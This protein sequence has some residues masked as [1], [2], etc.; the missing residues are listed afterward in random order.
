MVSPEAEGKDGKETEGKG[1][2]A[3]KTRGTKMKVVIM[4]QLAEEEKGAVEP[5]ESDG[6]RRGTR[7]ATAFSSQ[8]VRR[9]V[10][11]YD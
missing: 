6:G 2:S 11:Y 10:N 5:R 7:C 9:L 3:E 1:S 4:V 8:D